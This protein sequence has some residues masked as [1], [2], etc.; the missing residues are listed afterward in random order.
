MAE[1]ISS[2]LTG[3][4]L[5]REDVSAVTCDNEPAML[6]AVSAFTRSSVAVVPCAAHTIN[7]AGRKASALSSFKECFGNLLAIVEYFSNSPKRLEILQAKQKRKGLPVVRFISPAPTRWNYV[8]SVIERCKTNEEAV[9]RL[10]LAD[11]LEAEVSPPGERTDRDSTSER[12]AS[13]ARAACAEFRAL[14]EPFLTAL[15]PLNILF[16]LIRAAASA[17]ADLS[18]ASSLTISK[19]IT[20]AKRLHTMATALEEHDSSM[21]S[22]FAKTF[23]AEINERFFYRELPYVIE[24]AEFLDPACLQ[25][26]LPGE[27]DTS[28]ERTKKQSDLRRTRESL[29]LTSA[30]GDDSPNASAASLFGDDDVA[31]AGTPCGFKAQFTSYVQS[32]GD[33]DPISD[34]LGWWRTHCSEYPLIARQARCVLAAQA[35]SSECER[36]FSTGA[37][38]VNKLRGRL[39]GPR[40]EKLILLSRCLAPTM[41]TERSSWESEEASSEMAEVAALEDFQ[42]DS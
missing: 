9:R 39:S 34:S 11:F 7:L 36:L 10:E 16:P 24:A 38:V 1:S 21:V 20:T 4:G 23:A 18:S 6:A 17:V 40:A 25:S 19:M 29:A 14:Q 26:R 32:V 33:S 2:M 37:H 28:R 3:L 27:G 22:E 12:A 42:S 15:P 35:S 13:R 41:S 31:I 8:A 30:P 5:T